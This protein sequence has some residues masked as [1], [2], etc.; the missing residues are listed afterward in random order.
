MNRSLQEASSPTHGCPSSE[1]PAPAPTSD[2]CQICQQRFSDYFAHIGLKLHQLRVANAEASLMI[3]D[4]CKQFKRS[5]SPLLPPKNKPIRKDTRK[6]QKPTCKRPHSQKE[7]GLGVQQAQKGQN[8]S[9]GLLSESP[10]FA[11]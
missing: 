1:L 3:E 7:Y 4:L 5:P 9:T 11:E 2:Y 6:T 8:I 10:G